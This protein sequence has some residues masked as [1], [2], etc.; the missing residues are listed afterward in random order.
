MA[1][2]LIS[3]HSAVSVKN[4]ALHIPAFRARSRSGL[5]LLF[6]LLPSLLAL[7][8]AYAQPS[9]ES[10]SQAQAQA[11]TAAAALAV[12]VT[13]AAAVAAGSKGKGKGKHGRGG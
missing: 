6:F 7:T 3:V 8:N 4:A 5:G 12:A 9:D 2:L 10:K 13:T 1:G 11:A